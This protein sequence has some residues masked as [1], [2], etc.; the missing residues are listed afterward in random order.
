MLGRVAKHV[1]TGDRGA[2]V[3]LMLGKVPASDM[4]VIESALVSA[5]FTIKSAAAAV[6]RPA[7]KPPLEKVPLP[8]PRATPTPP[9]PVASARPPTEIPIEVDDFAQEPDAAAAEFDLVQALEAELT[10]LRG[11][12]PFQVLNVGYEADDATVRGAF[13]ELTKKYHPDRF[14]R[15]QSERVR[16][17]AS[18][19]FI[20]IKE[21]YTKAAPAPQPAPSP[22]PPARR[23][24]AEELFGDLD[25]MEAAGARAEAAAMP[26]DV[27]EKTGGEE[28]D[29]LLAAGKLFEAAAAYEALLRIR[30]SLRPARAGREL[31]S[32]LRDAAAGDRAAAA[33]HFEAA[34]EL[35]PLNE[36]AARELAALRRGATEQRRGFLGKLLGRKR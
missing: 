10:G 2:G 33:R 13:N 16:A 4:W 15:Y 35:D 22:P 5:G 19:I 28:A 26:L 8:P 29:R 20:V 11:M 12:N 30:P 18:D 1:T 9:K 21:A 36:R 7:A 34:L 25:G 14:A 31:V 24:T 23:L 17:L 3:E 27:E 32:G 6:A